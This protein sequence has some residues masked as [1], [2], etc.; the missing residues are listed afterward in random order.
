MGLRVFALSGWALTQAQL[1]LFPGSTVIFIMENTQEPFSLLSHLCYK[2]KYLKVTATSSKV[3]LSPQGCFS[4]P[5]K[6]GMRLG[7]CELMP[8]WRKVGSCFLLT[9]LEEQPGPI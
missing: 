8:A 2:V 3:T 5:T 1:P 6:Q 4:C 7:Q 9:V